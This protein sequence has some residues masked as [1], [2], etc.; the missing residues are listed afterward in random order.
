[1]MLN[2]TV[3]DSDPRSS[4]NA[5]AKRVR[6]L[7]A[8]TCL[9]RRKFALLYSIPPSTLQNWETPHSKGTGLT[10]NGA[11]KLSLLVRSAG[12]ECSAE[13]LLHGAGEPPRVVEKLSENSQE[14]GSFHDEL[15]LFRQH[16]KYAI[17]LVVND[18]GM[19]P[20]YQ[21]GDYVAGDRYHKEKMNLLLDS[22]CIVHLAS[23]QL[24]LRR[25]KKGSMEGFYKLICTNAHTTVE[26]P[27]LYDI[28]LV[29]AAPVL[30]SRRRVEEK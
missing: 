21:E 27:V 11:Q 6:S 24:L 10:V 3:E 26:K 1:M 9:S 16:C 7:R 13:W 15:Q 19:S 29:S 4:K 20:R 25:L 23:G 12:V 8:I 14:T 5:R 2:N 30:W 28:E 22:D 18:D 17:E